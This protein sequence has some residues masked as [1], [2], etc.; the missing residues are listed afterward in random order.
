VA[1]TESPGGSLVT[2]PSGAVVPERN[3]DGSLKYGPGGGRFVPVTDKTGNVVT[4]AAGNVVVEVDERGSM[5]TRSPL[6]LNQLDGSSL[7][8]N[9]YGGKEVA[10]VKNFSSVIEGAEEA[11]EPVLPPVTLPN[12]TVV[13][14]G[15]NYTLSAQIQKLMPGKLRPKNGITVKDVVYVYLCSFFFHI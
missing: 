11:G 4:N 6:E 7:D 14:P 12:G 3:P 9:V 1:R 13:V 15:L 8:P 5:V 2:D 10:V